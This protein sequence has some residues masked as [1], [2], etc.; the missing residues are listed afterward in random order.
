MGRG[1]HSAS[2]AAPFQLASG[3]PILAIGGFNGTDQ[4]PTLA[5]F[6]ELVAEG[7]VH[8]WA[9]AAASAAAGGG[10]ASQIAAWVTETFEAQTV[11]GTTVYDLTPAQAEKSTQL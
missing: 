1:D 3:E 9:A 10:T 8:Y 2:G 6:Q 7:K 5:A 4:S 11:G